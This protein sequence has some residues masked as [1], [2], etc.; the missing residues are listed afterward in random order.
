MNHNCRQFCLG[1]S[2]PMGHLDVFSSSAPDALIGPRVLTN[3]ESEWKTG[4]V[5]MMQAA[6]EK[7][8][9]QTHYWQI[10][11]VLPAGAAGLAA[12]FCHSCDTVS[13]AR[14]AQSMQTTEFR[15]V[16][17][18]FSFRLFKAG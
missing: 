7:G 13:L 6:A 15:S 5:W 14:L 3:S 16:V 11:D 12:A 2:S 18:S 17:L 8:T 4:A 1:G 9:A 10:P